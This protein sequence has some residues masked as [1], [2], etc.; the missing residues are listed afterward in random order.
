MFYEPYPENN[1]AET[2]DVNIL[3]IEEWIWRGDPEGRP[4]G[5]VFALLFPHNVGEMQQM[6]NP[7][8]DE[9][10]SELRRLIVDLQRD[11]RKA[12]QPILD[13]IVYLE[14]SKPPKPVI[15]PIR[16]GVPLTTMHQIEEAKRMIKAA[17]LPELPE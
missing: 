7:T 17:L 12:A 14:S 4:L 13:K 3:P 6:T 15:I 8:I 9:Q 2:G 5:A 11:Y 10:I 1:T 16:Q